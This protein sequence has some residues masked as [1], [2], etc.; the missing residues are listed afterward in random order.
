MRKIE[1]YDTTLRDGTQAEDFN[2]S[3]EDKIR[4]SMKLDELGIHYI[5]GGWPGSNPKDVGYFKEIKNYALKHSKV[6]AFGS[7]HN[8]R[9]S[10][11]KDPNL[12]ALLKAKTEVMTIFGKSWTVHVR[13]ALRTSLE[14][15]LE[16]IHNS[17]AYLRP[18]V[19]KL[20]YDAEHF[21]DGFKADPDYALATLKAGLDGG[22]HCLVLCDTNGGTLTSELIEIIKRVKTEFPKAE[23]GI[24]THNDSE[25][26]V[27]NSLAAVELGAN[28]VQGTMNGVGER[29]G[30]ANLCSII[31]AIKVKMKLDCIT[32]EQLTRLRET[33]RYILELAN[34]R[35]HKYQPYVGRSA[36]AHKGGIH[37]AAVERNPETY[38]HMR[39]ELVGNRQRILVSDLSGRATIKQKA[40]QYGME[41]SSKDPIAMQ[42]LEEL[43][44][45]EHEGF[46]YE[47]AEGSFELLMN[48]AIG[49]VKRYFE[50]IGFRVLVSKTDENQPSQAEATV[51]VKVGGKVEHTA[52]T[53]VGPVNALDNA[54]R[55]ALENFY[56]ELANMRLNDYKVRVLPGKEGTAAKVRVLIESVDQE[57]IWGT[58]GVSQDIL[59]ASWLALVDSINYKMFK[60]EDRREKQ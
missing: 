4:C 16:I 26:A 25:L 19:S 44:E 51:M 17:L 12:A 30:N 6:A 28:H 48:R 40:K 7:T 21:F 5:E 45:L 42:V 34:I 50:L 32:D 54:L 33:S 36:F 38:E 3:L 43:K 8:P 58:V 29:C 18:H 35:P 31:P 37:V 57:N 24:H 11:E 55:K 15:N 56:P 52:A 10:A 2:L 22:G 49:K 53:G 46:Q 39:P 20:F 59:E 60:D 47:A 9:S 23:L 14:R 1:L 13:D 41:I 27:A